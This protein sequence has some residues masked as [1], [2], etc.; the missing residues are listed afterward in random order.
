MRVPGQDA[1]GIPAGAAP[2]REE[3]PPC[4]VR[5]MIAHGSLIQV[6]VS[7]PASGY[8]TSQ[9]RRAGLMTAFLQRRELLAGRRKDARPFP[10]PLGALVSETAFRTACTQCGACAAACPD[11]IIR[12]DP[13]GFPVVD[14]SAGGCS[15]CGTCAE[16]CP[17][18]A[19]SGNRTWPWRLAVAGTCLGAFGVTCRACEDNCDA[20]ALRF[21]PMTKGRSAVG[22]DPDRCTGCGAC[23]AACPVGALALVP[24]AQAPLS[25]PGP[26]AFVAAPAPVPVSAK[27]PIS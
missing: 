23:I 21:T 15:F 5:L 11:D 16:A 12:R 14:V 18:T 7:R 27:E 2:V 25:G 1:G 17:A 20:A 22:I 6:N 19:L 3:R 8:R 13:R 9:S 24:L 10:R 26:D 4:Y